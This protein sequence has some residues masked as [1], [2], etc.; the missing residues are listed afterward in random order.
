MAEHKPGAGRVRTVEPAT[1]RSQVTAAFAQAGHAWG[2]SMHAATELYRVIAIGDRFAEAGQWT[3]AQIV[4]A[5]VVDEILPSY[6]ELE[7]EDQIAGVLGGCLG[8]LLSCLEAQKE[9][10]AEDRLEDADRQAL[11]TS[12]FAL[13]KHGCEYGLE[14]DEIPVLNLQQRNRKHSKQ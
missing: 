1:I 3:N 4:Y 13:W 9:L 11:L 2:C 5:T 6:E 7:E 14:V 12:P 10:Q 8:G